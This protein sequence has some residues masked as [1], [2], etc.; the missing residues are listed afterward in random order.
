[1]KMI[2]QDTRQIEFGDFQTP[3]E[4]AG[5]VVRLLAKKM[6][7]PAT[8]VEPTCGRGSFLVAALE[9][10]SRSQ[11]AIGVEINPEYFKI[12]HQRIASLR[13]GQKVDLRQADFFRF[14]W[15][16][17]FDSATGPIWVIGNPPWVTASQ[18]GALES[19]NLPGK[20][21][22]QNHRGLDAITGKSNFD[23]AE[24]MLIHLLEKLLG[25]DAVLAMLVKTSVARKVL[26]HAWKQ[27][28]PIAEAEIY[29]IDAKKHF[30]VSV[31]AGLLVCRLGGGKIAPRCGLFDMDS[32]DICKN[33]LA[34]HNGWVLADLEAFN[35]H[36]GLLQDPHSPPLY[37]WRS[38]VKHDCSKVM[39]LDKQPQSLMNGHGE[40]VEIEPTYLY[41]MLKGSAVANG[42]K[43]RTS[44]Y[45]LVT[46][47]K[48]GEPTEVIQAAAPNTWNYLLSHARELDER[49]SSIYRKR[50][51]FSVF[52][53]GKYA[54]SPWKVAICG[55]YK[56][57][58][59]SVIGP[60]DGKPVVVDD[61]T[62]FLS[63]QSEEE[64]RLLADLLETTEAREFLGSF[65][66]WDAKRPITAEIL[67]RLDMGALAK[68]QGKL[69]TLMALRQDEHVS[70]GLYFRT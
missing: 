21:N 31:E 8:I 39:E 65:I 46:Q 10:C 55:L 64:A 49:G 66:F 14:D 9:Q 6:P 28:W 51:R 30:G 36:I 45:M 19:G 29:A 7:A 38:G 27:A 25:K 69:K 43:T 61:T 5:E 59:F 60:R 22:F 42:H 68:M 12:A 16:K 35:R 26:C 15:G 40:T 54:F 18:L 47:T 58:A 44:R 1:M 13:L 2:G 70:L 53:I 52:G 50:P 4:L 63:C 33:S 11:A 41:P 20:S 17:V 57:L 62:Y 48:T 23:I 3:D 56:R 32:P 24:W 34:F 67:G 37:R